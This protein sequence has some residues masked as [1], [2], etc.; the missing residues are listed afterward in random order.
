MP[1]NKPTLAEFLNAKTV[2]SSLQEALF[3]IAEAGCDIAL[4]IRGAELADMV[5][6]AGGVN[7]QGEGQ[8]KLDVFA[9]DVFLAHG[10]KASVFSAMV[11]EEM[12]GAVRL[13]KAGKYV[14]LF[15][16]LDGSANSDVHMPTGSIF[17]ILPAGETMLLAGRE[18]IAAGYMLYGAA[19]VLI[20][21]IGEGVHG[22]IL[23]EGEKAFRLFR[24]NIS[25]PKS[26]KEYAIN[27]ARAPL[28]GEGVQRY[29]G[30]C[31]ERGFTMRWVG[32]MVADVHRI[33]LRGGVFLYPIDS[34]LAEKGGRLR[35]L[36]EAAP[37]S[38]IIEQAG[39][40]ATSGEL[41]IMDIVPSSLHERV[42]V[43]L[44]VADEV[45]R[46]GVNNL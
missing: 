34:E 33:L 44:G 18:Q 19:T 26:A 42:G 13:S 21:T 1:R 25:I 15:D 35:L 16:P 30:E 29:I 28:W 37:M 24:E 40:A 17:S 6:E 7:V 12:E 8:K 41:P 38:F 3:A 36:Y 22:F 27:A 39:G 31:V 9:N 5:G 14:L 32:A 11:S 4:A 45:G 23:D 43:V 46:I 2:A 20:L 10:K